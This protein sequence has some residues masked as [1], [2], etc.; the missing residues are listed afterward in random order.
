MDCK[1][2]ENIL[3]EKNILKNKILKGLEI[4]KN[5][6]IKNNLI[7]VGGM[8]MDLALKS[9]GSCI[10]PENH[11]PDYDFYSPNFH[12]ISYN[13]AKECLNQGLDDISVINATH[14]STMRVRTNFEVIADSTYIP[15]N[16]YKK[17]PFLTIKKIRIVHPWYQMI[18][19]HRSLSLPYENP[20][21][22]TFNHRWKKDME[23]YDLL[24][25]YFPL[26]DVKLKIKSHKIME[27][28]LDILQN[29]C[30]SGFPALLFW[31]TTAQKEGFKINKK[32]KCL[33]NFKVFEEALLLSIPEGTKATIY[34][35]D[36]SNLINKIEQFIGEFLRVKRKIGYKFEPILGG[37]K[38][39]EE[40]KKRTQIKYFNPFLD[41]LPQKAEINIYEIFDN[42]NQLLSAYKWNKNIYIANLQNIMLY[43]LMRFIIIDCKVSLLGYHLARE[44]V[45]WGDIKYNPTVEVYGSNNISESYIQNHRKL[46][47]MFGE[48]KQE[49]N[50]PKRIYPEKISDIKDKI[51]DFIPSESD[52][53]QFNGKEIDKLKLKNDI[54]L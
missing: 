43:L 7:L 13:I 54:N 32:Y 40:Y 3:L 53:Y 6:I 45:E 5:T 18:D 30:L 48:L 22:E 46:K 44:L 8:A 15:E 4:T 29:Q 51:Y 52:I 36:I 34:S 35:D 26:P 49:Q 1:K 19:Q 9:K 39:D 21:M 11:L 47:M 31:A 12:I 10:Y 14:I 50:K 20:P 38:K 23:R 24:Y 16:I 2:Y 28:P 37:S 25:K 27:I 17:I 33:G 41:K 42:S